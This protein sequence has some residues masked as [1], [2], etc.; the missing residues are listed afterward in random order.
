MSR[1]DP[2]THLVATTALGSTAIQRLR[3]L[4]VT[5]EQEGQ[6]LSM[7]A[8]LAACSDNPDSIRDVMTVVYQVLSMGTFTAEH[9]AALQRAHPQPR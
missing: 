2:R 3:D 5:P 6:Y 1:R 9:A 8:Q 7:A 4:G